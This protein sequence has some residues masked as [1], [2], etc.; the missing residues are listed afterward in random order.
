MNSKSK[1]GKAKKKARRV[2]ATHSG[3]VLL[4]Q[5]MADGTDLELKN[6]L[7]VPEARHNV[8]APSGGPC[9]IRVRIQG[10]NGQQEVLAI[11]ST[12]TPI[13]YISRSFAQRL[14]L[15]L[16]PNSATFTDLFRT[17]LQGDIV[18]SLSIQAGSAVIVLSP[19]LVLG[20]L[21]DVQLGLDFMV[22]AKALTFINY[23]MGYLRFTSDG[24]YTAVPGEG[25][26]EF[27]RL[28]DGLPQQEDIP[29]VHTRD[30]VRNGMIYTPDT[31][32]QTC[33]GCGLTFWG[34]S[35]CAA[36]KTAGSPV[37]YCCRACQRRD[38]PRHKA[39]ECAKS[40]SKDKEGRREEKRR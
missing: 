8:I 31:P 16:L 23:A 24:E 35:C 30:G 27:V 20:T 18:R 37:Y 28:F 29:I 1:K 33:A 17:R 10:A 40:H 2:T 36:C 6:A 11:T 34:F 12:A 5:M 15:E 38:W 19:V 26:G 22:A 13:T 39:H 25:D 4:P 9:A 3:T 14:Q 32:K 7:Y 21:R